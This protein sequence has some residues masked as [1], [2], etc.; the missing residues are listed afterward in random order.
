MTSGP[1]TAVYA[2]DEPENTATA[3]VSGSPDAPPRVA[4]SVPRAVG[5]AVVRNRVRRRL[6]SILA[7]ASSQG[8]VAPGAWLFI[9]R[10]PAADLGFH[11]LDAVVGSILGRVATPRVRS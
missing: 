6:R 2:P 7:T 8:R 11:D 5:S 10:P 1:I 9:V 4:F 3:G